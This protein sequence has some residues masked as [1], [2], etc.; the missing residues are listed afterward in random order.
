[1]KERIKW[2]DIL[3]ALAMFAV[4]LGHVVRGGEVQTYLYSFHFGLFMFI[5]GLVTS[6]RQESFG[7]FLRR[8][9]RRLLIPY[10]FFGVISVVIYQVLG[11]YAA[12]ALGEEFN[13]SL[14][15]NL[16]YLL[17]GSSKNGQMEYNH[18]LWSLTCLFV[19]DVIYYLLRT[20]R[21][22]PLKKELWLTGW[23]PVFALLGWLNSTRWQ[24]VL[25]FQAETALI[26]MVFYL[27]GR[28][29]REPLGSL[30]MKKPAMLAVG[31][32]L[33]VIAGFIGMKNGR[34]R[35]SGDVYN[36]YPLF[37]LSAFGSIIGYLLMARVIDRNRVL[38]YVGASTMAILVMHK[39]PVLFFQTIVPQTRKLLADNNLPVALIVAVIAIAMCL[40]AERIILLICPALVGKKKEK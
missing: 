35:Y 18:P 13:G 31:L 23:I 39:F 29:L 38:E 20:F 14:L 27:A 1:M 16:G 8:E 21:P 25:P 7:H 37:W 10:L 36:S 5:S 3:R 11:R 30:K 24:L 32:L 2:I 9:F 28:L 15:T 6:D 33:I 17:Y 19:C 4:V 12:G 26:M 40:I 34:V 22:K